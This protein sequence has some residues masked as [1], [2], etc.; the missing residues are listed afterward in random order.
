MQV[1]PHCLAQR[2]RGGVA[3]RGGAHVLLGWQRAVH[4]RA[5]VLQRLQ[6]TVSW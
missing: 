3:P 6:A 4:Y 1:G 2:C 5:L